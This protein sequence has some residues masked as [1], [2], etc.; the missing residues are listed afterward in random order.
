MNRIE[1]HKE[2]YKEEIWKNYSLQ[3]LGMWVHLFHKR[4][5]HR[6]NE[7]KARKD[8]YDAKNYLWMIEQN[9]KSRAEE[10][11]IDYSSL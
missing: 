9:L 1:K 11:N 2:D 7:E 6:D 5:L 4:S 3:E 10:L 8:L